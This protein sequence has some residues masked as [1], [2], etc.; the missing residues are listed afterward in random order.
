MQVT[1][2]EFLLMDIDNEKIQELIAGY[3]VGALDDTE[4]SQAEQLLQ[5]SEEAR[6]LL[7][8]FQ[9]V[10]AG[11]ALS[12]DPVELPAGSLDRLRQKAGFA[13]AVTNPPV[14]PALRP[15]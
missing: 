7:A 14:Q 5:T 4:N 6:Q 3:A 13:A 8:E 12:V 9:E 10:T 1:N 11:L 2:Q 15:L